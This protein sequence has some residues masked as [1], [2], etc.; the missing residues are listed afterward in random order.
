MLKTSR[1]VAVMLCLSFSIAN[2]QELDSLLNIGAFTAE[3][4]LQKQLNQSTKVASGFSLSTRET[5]GILSVVTSE[6]I[7]NAGARDLMDVLRLIPGFDIGQD[8]QFVQGISLR[9]NWAN[10]G[11]VL[12][13]LD[14]QP[15]NELLYQT[16]AIGNR[17]PV[18]AI[19]KIEVI[20]GPGSAIYGGSAEYGV[21]NI[22]TKAANSL[23]GVMVH[24]IAG[25]HGEATGRTNGGVMVSQKGQNFSW[26]FS[27]FGGKGIMSDQL[28][29][30]FGKE[31]DPQD[32]S[33]TSAADPTN[34]NLGL[35]YKDLKARVMYDA[36]AIEEPTAQVD[37]RSLYAD[38]SYQ[39][40]VSSKFALTPRFQYIQQHPWDYDY[41]ETPE[42]DFDIDAS[43]LLGQVD[44][45]YN[46]SRKVSVNMGALYFVDEG[47]DNLA[48]E[49]LTLNNFA[50]YTQALFKH[51]LANATLGFRFEKNNRYDGAFVPRLAL[52]KKIENLHFKVLY[53]RAFRSPSIQNIKLDTTGAEPE[54]SNVA[55][56]ELGYQFT[57]EM[58]FSL[59]AF[60]ISTRDVLIYGSEGTGDEFSEWYENYD[61]SG[62]TG[63]ELLY[64][65]R[66]K[67]WYTH[68][69]YSFSQALSDNTVDKYEAP[70]S[71]KQYLGQLAHKLTVNS[72]VSISNKITL[73]PTI[74]YGGKRFAYTG[75]DENGD[76][77]SQELDPY[78]L[79][80]VFVN[81]K[82]FVPGLTLGLGAY[83]LLNERPAIPQA[84]N[85]EF[86]VIPGRSREYV[87]KLSYQ[88]NFD[89]NEK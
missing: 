2:A 63:L 87:I 1:Y 62:S 73:N 46:P 64:S 70:Q 52:T 75:Y 77:Q 25:L 45:V 7:Q 82:N 3:S 10:E 39:Y 20:R 58:L 66:K 51:R 60:Y 57:P 14:G 22:L 56:F 5:P 69:T 33:K 4:D 12:V 32:L 72:N 78:T 76:P 21:I 65:I 38:L 28:Y 61:K 16:V 24:G 80:N 54:I 36:Y 13:L 86:G 17:F 67:N 35:R 34:I 68:V 55:E 8:L 43:R 41:K 49:T 81:Y 18:D 50:V 37:Y 23:N 59:N 44:G 27:A 30:D 9:G 15:M 19:D 88:L 79:V 11:K 84:Y 85:G 53:S 6:E 29:Q 83:D 26:D 31:L 74:I 47:V 89:K 40:Q 48:D 71:T 42:D